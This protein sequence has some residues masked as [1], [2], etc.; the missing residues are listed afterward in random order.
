MRIGF[1]LLCALLAA[2]A[3]E[4]L[5]EG[6]KAREAMREPLAQPGTASPLPSY[7]DYEAERT[8][9]MER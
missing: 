4:S 7:A 8:R 3:S 5:Y 9:L 2:C 6:F 1:W